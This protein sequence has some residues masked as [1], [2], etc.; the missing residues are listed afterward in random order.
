[1]PGCE[2]SNNI[3]VENFYRLSHLYL[4]L[5]SFIKPQLTRLPSRYSTTVYFKSKILHLLSE[6]S[7]V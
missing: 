2:I 1:M 6:L 5:V 7:S 4:E 3:A